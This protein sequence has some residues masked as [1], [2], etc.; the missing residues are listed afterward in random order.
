[1]IYRIKKYLRRHRRPLL[2]SALVLAP[3]LVL[4]AVGYLWI[5]SQRTSRVAATSLLANE[6]IDEAQRLRGE[7]QAGPAGDLSKW[8]E[9]LGAA[10][11]AAGYVRQGEAN[12][13]L[14]A[15]VA[16]LLAEI[17]R[18]RTEA[19]EQSRQLA[20]DRSLLSELES[21]RGARADHWDW[22]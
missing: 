7:A 13:A 19:Q 10:S 8:N 6:A 12:I 11:R 22:K 20:I 14:R 17:G 21:I 4:G 2:T 9:A 3:L 16:G 15:R 1:R 18:E 5:E